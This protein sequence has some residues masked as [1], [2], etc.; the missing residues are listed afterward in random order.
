MI[1]DFANTLIDG[2]GHTNVMDMFKPTTGGYNSISGWLN[3][4]TSGT[5]GSVKLLESDDNSSYSDVAGGTVTFTAAGHKAIVFPKTTKRYVKAVLTSA[6][7]DDL[8]TSNTA[9]F[10][11][12]LSEEKE[13]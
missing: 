12:G 7:G 4:R 10:V 13:F 2:A 1:I 6:Q 9:V 8:T 3:I 11:G 5:T